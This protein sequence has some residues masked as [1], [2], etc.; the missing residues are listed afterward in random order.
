[1]SVDKYKEKIDEIYE[2]YNIPRI[3]PAPLLEIAEALGYTVQYFIVKPDNKD[4]AGATYYKEKKIL[5]SPIVFKGRGNF[6]IAHELGHIILGHDKDNDREYDT[7]AEIL[8]P[9]RKTK[10]YDANEFAAELLMPATKLKEI[11]EEKQDLLSLALFFNVTVAAVK[12][13]MERLGMKAAVKVRME[14]LG[15]KYEEL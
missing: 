15:M 3:Y 12:I 6:T 9:E 14:R 11:L 10:E 4:L 8:A 1:M 7:R 13:R 5:I 2:K